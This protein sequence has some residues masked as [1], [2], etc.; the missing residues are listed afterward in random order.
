M[1]VMILLVGL[2]GAVA[3]VEA[4]PIESS[5]IL[6]AAGIGKPSPRLSGAQARL[7]ARRAAEVRAVRNL[8]RKLGHRGPATVRGFRYRSTEYLSDGSVKVDVESC[9]GRAR[10]RHT[11]KERQVPDRRRTGDRSA[12]S[13]ICSPDPHKTHLRAPG[14]TFGSQESDDALCYNVAV[15]DQEAAHGFV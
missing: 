3:E 14:C 4:V 6:R 8:A 7:M 9:A 13:F 11:A 10:A 5:P 2:L 15:L 12:N 1:P